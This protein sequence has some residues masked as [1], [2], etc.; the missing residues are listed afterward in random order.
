MKKIILVIALL[1]SGV[2]SADEDPIYSSFFGGAIDGYDVVAYFTESK[3]VKGHKNISYKYKDAKWRFSSEENRKLF[4]A[5]PQKYTPEFGG[6]C[7]F[8]MSDDRFV[9]IDGRAWTI[10]GGK[11]YLNY[12]ESVQ[13]HWQKEQSKLIQ[14]ADVNWKNYWNL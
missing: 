14:E 8:A 6:Y 5:N 3:A 9:K 11:L 12:S 4:I 13:S 10:V 7:A 1:F 2:L